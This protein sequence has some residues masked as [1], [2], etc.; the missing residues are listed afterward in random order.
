MYFNQLLLMD[1]EVCQSCQILHFFLD[2]VLG[3]KYLAYL[4]MLPPTSPNFIKHV[5]HLKNNCIGKAEKLTTM[6]Y[7]FNLQPCKKKIK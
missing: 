1:T 5:S 2:T 4:K 6:V 7:K 3:K